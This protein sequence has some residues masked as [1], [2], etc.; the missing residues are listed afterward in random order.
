VVGADFMLHPFA[1]V[2]I[3]AL[4]RIP[5]RFASI[6][7]IGFWAV[8]HVFEASTTACSKIA[9]WTHIGGFLKCALLVVVLRRRGV[10]LFDRAPAAATTPTERVDEAPTR[11]IGSA[12][13]PKTEGP[14]G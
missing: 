9:G 5:M 8:F 1:K 7:T 11:G 6:W 13:P 14:R 4:G 3:P 12:A 10:V 2:W